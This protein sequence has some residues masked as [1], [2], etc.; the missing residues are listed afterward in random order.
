MAAVFLWHNIANPGDAGHGYCLEAPRR[1]RVHP[2]QGIDP[3]ALVPRMTRQSGKAYCSESLCAG[4]A[5]RGKNRRNQNR[6]SS[7]SCRPRH[8][9]GIMGRRCHQTE[10]PPRSRR[11]RQQPLRQMHTISA[12]SPGQP[13]IAGH[14][15]Q[16]TALPAQIG[17]GP[18]QCQPALVGPF[19]MPQNHHAAPR[20][21]AQRRQ[22]IWQPPSIGEQDQS[23]PRS[24]S[25]AGLSSDQPGC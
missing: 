18:R 3:Q 14:Q 25:A 23:R 20:Q 16:Q 11:Q 15:K 4:V 9:A 8:R 17:H 19:I 13:C 21:A 12:Q 22:R 6:I 24:G 10:L 7:R 2:P 5:G 1:R